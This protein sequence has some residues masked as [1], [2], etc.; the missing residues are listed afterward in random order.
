M[1]KPILPPDQLKP[2][3]QQLSLAEEQ[4]LAFDAD[5]ARRRRR[6]LLRLPDPLLRN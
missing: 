2:V 1:D 4:R 6:P 3:T 5:R